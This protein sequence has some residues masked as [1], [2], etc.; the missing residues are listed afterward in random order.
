MN[1]TP[2]ADRKSES[3]TSC[4]TGWIFE[5][6][7]NP[8]TGYSWIP[9]LTS[10]AAAI[11]SIAP[12]PFCKLV[13]N[14]RSGSYY[15]LYQYYDTNY[16]QCMNYPDGIDVDSS[17]RTARAFA[18][19]GG[20]SGGLSCLWFWFSGVIHHSSPSVDKLRWQA[21]A[22]TSLFACLSVGLS[23]LILDSNLC[24]DSGCKLASEGNVI[25][26]GCILFGVTG[27]VAFLGFPPER[28]PP[29]NPPEHH[30]VTTTILPD[31]RVV[32]DVVVTAVR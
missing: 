26:A 11:C 19:I 4:C 13:S 21:S 32:T 14:K 17:W 20:I 23:L 15:G 6:F 29:L 31:G 18:I 7:R 9:V 24:D 10:T 3:S 2:Q 30:T 16:G 27:V 12:L 28:L 5:D 8:Y 22:A 1:R 25:L